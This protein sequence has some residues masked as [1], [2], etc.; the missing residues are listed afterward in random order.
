MKTKHP[1]PMTI[2]TGNK[3]TL[4]DYFNKPLDNIVQ[5]LNHMVPLFPERCVRFIEDNG[6][7]K[8]QIFL[9]L[10]CILVLQLYPLTSTHTSLEWL[11]P[12]C[13]HILTASVKKYL[14][15]SVRRK[16]CVDQCS[17]IYSYKEVFYLEA[18]SNT[19]SVCDS[20][21]CHL[22]HLTEIMNLFVHLTCRSMPKMASPTDTSSCVYCRHSNRRPVQD[23]SQCQGERNDH[24]EIRWRYHVCQTT[25]DYN[26]NM[27]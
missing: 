21:Y 7:M 15:L 14:E 19:K 3:H 2:A 10:H 9:V 11:V 22:H 12:L 20:L 1:R 6:T 5:S 25:Y 4:S 23:T 26:Y 8:V 17:L 16:D 13:S 18:L 27:P 24:K